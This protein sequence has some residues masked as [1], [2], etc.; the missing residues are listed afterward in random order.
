MARSAGRLCMQGGP[1]GTGRQG[2]V[3]VGMRSG[4]ETVVAAKT[5]FTVQVGGL[6]SGNSKMILRHH[7]LSCIYDTDIHD[8]CNE[9][10]IK[11]IKKEIV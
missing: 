6:Q 5:I 2:R 7:S 3:G 8:V 9:S 1:Q 11:G 10:G 4:H